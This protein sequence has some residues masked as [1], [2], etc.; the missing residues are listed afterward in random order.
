MSAFVAFIHHLAAFSL[1]SAMVLEKVHLRD[2]IA[3]LSNGVVDHG[4]AK[5]LARA[6]M[7]FGISAGVLLMVGIARVLWFE[8]GTGYYFH[9]IPFILKFSLFVIAG[10][11]SIV[12]TIEF[13]KWGKALKAGR[14]VAADAAKLGQLRLIVMLENTAVVGIILCAALMAKGIG[15]IG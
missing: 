10:L 12:P 14:P 9:S 8:K 2:A 15:V 11:L 7:I 3:T 1:V 5:K 4:I 6:D 13:A